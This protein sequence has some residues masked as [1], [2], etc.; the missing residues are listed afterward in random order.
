MQDSV[1]LYKTYAANHQHFQMD[2]LK[3][4]LVG[5]TLFME[6][7]NESKRKMVKQLTTQICVFFI[8]SSVSEHIKTDVSAQSS[9]QSKNGFEKMH[10]LKDS[11]KTLSLNPSMYSKIFSR[12]SEKY[13][14]P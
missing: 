3:L 13:V 1:R 5:A 12:V 4:S 2:E 9:E 6:C 14:A 8:R 10:Q 7:G 11:E